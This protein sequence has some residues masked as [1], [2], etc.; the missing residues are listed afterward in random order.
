MNERC[1]CKSIYERYFMDNYTLLTK[2]DEPR[3][4]REDYEE[5]DSYNN[6]LDRA[7]THEAG[8]FEDEPMDEAGENVE[9]EQPP[10]NWVKFC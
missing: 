7:H 1:F 8:A 4:V 5:E 3:V 10:L 2:R 6:I 9:E